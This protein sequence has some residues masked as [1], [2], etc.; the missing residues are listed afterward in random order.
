M[1]NRDILEFPLEEVE[2]P[3]AIVLMMQA[4]TKCTEPPAQGV[5]LERLQLLAEKLEARV[6]DAIT[7][8]VDEAKAVRDIPVEEDEP[9]RFE[10][11]DGHEMHLVM[12][13]DMIRQVVVD[14]ILF[15]LACNERVV[16]DENGITS[17][18]IKQWG[19][20]L[21]HCDMEG[22]TR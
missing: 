17:T 14:G 1:G 5:D 3:Q 12:A 9:N 6:E 21:E 4:A 10:P 15:V 13:D 19:H 18:C 11:V 8:A 2:V 20:F 16:T 22:N 7:D